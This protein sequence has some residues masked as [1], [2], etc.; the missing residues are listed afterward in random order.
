MISAITVGE[1]GFGHAR[2]TSP[3]PAKQN[4]FRKFIR[5]H[6]PLPLPVTTSTATYYGP[7]RG[8]LFRKYPPKGKKQRRPEQCFDTETALELGID[9]NDLWIASQAY[10]R[11]LVLVTNDGMARIRDVAGDLLTVENWSKPI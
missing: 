2:T 5:E 1:I 4:A 10:E 7:L 11:N 3:D 8:E 6:F 9:E